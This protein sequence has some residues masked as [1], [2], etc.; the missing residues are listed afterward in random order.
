M[1]SLRG[2][3]DRETIDNYVLS[4]R[5][6]DGGVNG[7]NILTADTTYTINVLEVNEDPPEFTEG[8]VYYV[9]VPED[10]GT[11]QILQVR[12]IIFLNMI[13]III[14]N[15]LVIKEPMRK[16]HHVRLLCLVLTKFVT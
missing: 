10:E 11:G 2:I 7:A 8:G 16:K 15:P 9:D 3:L 12:K 6:S 14:I 13:C 5:V 4:V 1:I